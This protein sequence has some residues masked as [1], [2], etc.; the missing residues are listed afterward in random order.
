MK[1]IDWI[2]IATIIGMIVFCFNVTREA[3]IGDRRLGENVL[4]LQTQIND[5]RSTLRI[6]QE[7]ISRVRQALIVTRQEAGNRD[8]RI[9][10]YDY[11][12]KRLENPEAYKYSP[13]EYDGF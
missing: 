11:R 10:N 2:L 13:T 3:N 5:L 1:K 9:D 7:N 12:I 6:E 8:S 4:D